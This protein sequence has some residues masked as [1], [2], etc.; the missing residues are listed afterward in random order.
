MTIN[1][2]LKLI[3]RGAVE[4]IQEEELRKK[5]ESSAK[6]KKPLIVKAGFDPS[7]PDI[8]LGHTVLLRK[9]RHF[10]DLGHKVVFLIGDFT[11]MIGDPSGQ[12]EI[13]KKLTKKEVLQNAAT[14]KKQVFKILDKNPKKL[15]IV[16]NS[17]WMEKMKAS[18]LL[19]LTSR[20]TVT[21]M[22]ERDDFLKRYKANKPISMQEFL[23][24]LIQGYDS[25]VLKADIELGGTDQKFN[26]L[27]GRNLQRDFGQ[28]G[29]VVITMPLLVGLDGV[30]K[31]SKSYDNYVGITEPA[32]EIYGKLMSI[33]DE[34]MSAYYELLTDNVLDKSIHPKEAKKALAREIVGNFYNEARAKKAEDEFER[35]FKDKKLPTDIQELALDV[36][37]INIIELLVKS[38]ASSSKSEARRLVIQGAVSVAGEKIKDPNKT[39]RVTPTKQTLKAGK[40]FFLSYYKR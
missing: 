16:F 30:Q 29:Q 35:V 40:R 31:M 5:L 10:Q 9:L 2:Q 26:L 36:D 13:R 23:Y 25:V 18:E 12:S 4:V 11:G 3:K 8:H 21:R 38:G 37:E 33:S 7:A 6:T 22:L 27:V 34:L 24:P 32:N 17:S 19:N 28:D 20:Y 15:E 39:I 1:D 14:Y